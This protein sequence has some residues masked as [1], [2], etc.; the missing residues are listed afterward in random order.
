MNPYLVGFLL[1][2]VLLGTI[3]VTGRGL[4]A[5]GAIKSVVV[6]SVVEVAPPTFGQ[7]SFHQIVSRR[8]SRRSIKRLACLG[9]YWRGNRCFFFRSDFEP[10]WN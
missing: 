4:G 2:L 10:G 1:G 6:T 9:S 8:T 7:Y 3:Y 5:S